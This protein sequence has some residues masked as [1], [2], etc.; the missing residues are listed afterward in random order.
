MYW[1]NS[2]SKLAAV[3]I[4]GVLTF[5]L[6]AKTKVTKQSFGK[7][8]DGTPVDIYALDDATVEARIIT[9]GGIL[10][11][12]KVPDR[13]GKSMGMGW[14]TGPPLW[15]YAAVPLFSYAINTPAYVISS[16]DQKSRCGKSHQI[17]NK[18]RV[19]IQN[20]NGLKFVP[21]SK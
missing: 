11:S 7:L 19:S 3:L 21:L 13:L 14:D 6:E 18:K 20:F 15:P 2:G 4:L 17:G 5:S 16:P 10:Q 9:C 1:A 12:L 8:A